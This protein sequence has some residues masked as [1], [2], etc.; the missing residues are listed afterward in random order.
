MHKNFI[1]YQRLYKEFLECIDM[2][3]IQYQ[4]YDVNQITVKKYIFGTYLHLMV[5]FLSIFT[6]IISITG[7]IIYTKT[8]VHIWVFTWVKFMM[9]TLL[10]TM[11]FCHSYFVTRMLKP[12]LKC[13]I[14]CKPIEQYKTGQPQKSC[15]HYS[16][17][18][19]SNNNSISFSIKNH[20]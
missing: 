3:I 1:L 19:N 18:I 9:R 20:V 5:Y 17:P 2:D 12:L 13:I 8:Q 15:C 4:Q 11:S 7:Y 6:T 16:N 14:N 10:G